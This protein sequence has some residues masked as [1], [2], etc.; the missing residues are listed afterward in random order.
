MKAYA[1]RWNERDGSVRSYV[2]Q[3]NVSAYDGR[4]LA[5]VFQDLRM[6]EVAHC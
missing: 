2:M 6:S 1:A 3:W 4:S 5:E